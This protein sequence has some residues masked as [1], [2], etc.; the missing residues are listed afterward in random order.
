[1]T[2]SKSRVVTGYLLNS[3][4][5]KQSFTKTTFSADGS[6]TIVA[7]DITINGSLAWTGSEDLTGVKQFTGSATDGTF[8][9]GVTADK[10]DKTAAPTLGLATI[11]I[12]GVAGV[13]GGSGFAT[14]KG[15]NG[16]I[17]ATYTLADDDKHALLSTGS[18]SRSGNVPQWIVNLKSGSLLFGNLNVA[19]GLTN[20][21]ANSLSWIR[22]PTGN[23][24][25]SSSYP[26]GFTNAQF[27]AVCSPFSIAPSTF[28]G[29]FHV[30]TLGGA[31][32]NVD[33]VVTFAAGK[34]TP[35]GLVTA[36]LVDGNGKLKLQFMDGGALKHKTTAVGTILQNTTNGVGF[37]IQ[38]GATDAGSVTLT[39]Q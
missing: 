31:I 25:Y 21:S 38:A 9:A 4:N 5:Q 19:D 36:G 12:P 39:P 33:E 20:V 26:L 23:T 14:V 7:G 10:E 17:A 6:A 11:Q 30:T 2:V 8:T 18:S 35:V 34:A 16:S 28:A 32:S 29:T 1:M 24:V 3:V 37:Y 15:K 22:P 13:P 27:S